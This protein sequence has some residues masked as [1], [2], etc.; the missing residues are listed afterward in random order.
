MTCAHQHLHHYVF[1]SGICFFSVW[2]Y[3]EDQAGVWN[4]LINKL[5]PDCLYYCVAESLGS[6]PS[7]LKTA[8]LNDPSGQ[9]ICHKHGVGAVHSVVVGNSNPS[10]QS[11]FDIFLVFTGGAQFIAGESSMRKLSIQ[12][13]GTQQSRQ[14]AV[15]E[16][17]PFATDLFLNVPPPGQD[18]GGDHAWVDAS[19]DWVGPYT[20]IYTSRSLAVHHSALL[21]FCRSLCLTVLLSLALSC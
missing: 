13:T 16:S 6:N 18:I 15:V 4:P 9:P 8:V 11:E 12:V 1:S 20:I 19:G 5:L 10:D 14:V 2:K 17:T 21:C 7:C 3:Y